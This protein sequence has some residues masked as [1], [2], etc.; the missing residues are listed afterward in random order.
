MLLVNTEP[1][2]IL[3]EVSEQVATISLN[4]PEKLNA[5]DNRMISALMTSL[6]DIESDD[7]IRAIIL[8]GA[9]S[10]AFSAGADIQ[11]IA[12]KVN[13]G[14]EIALR[15]FVRPGQ[16][17]TKRIETFPKPIIAAVNGLAY[18][19]GC[20]VVEACPL[21]IASTTATFA[22]AEINLGFPPPFGGTQ[23]LP[24]LVG[25]KRALAMLLTGDP[26]PAAEAARIGL[27]N[28]V[29]PHEQLMP[30]ARA[31]A[32]RIA[33]KSAT[34]VTACL[35]AVTRGINLT[36]DEGLAVEASQF[37][38]MAPTDDIREGISAFLERRRPVFKA[39]ETAR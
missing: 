35:E 11:G 14:I 21:A 28:E 7:T 33:E 19:G 16:T 39:G 4:R 12:K 24:R 3:I 5:I 9:G 8:T 37:A 20:E 36:I 10:R 23:R 27:V 25:R 34:A 6:G 18:G 1:D 32:R 38:R 22:K 15:E 30:R 2:R 17:L 26:I 29:V 13:A 31:L